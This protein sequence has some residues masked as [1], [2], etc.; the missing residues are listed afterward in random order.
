M[1]NKKNLSTSE[2]WASAGGI[3]HHERWG[4]PK[5][6][7]IVHNGMHHTREKSYTEWKLSAARVSGSVEIHYS[8][9]NW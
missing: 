5:A 8:V 4:L 3:W 9:G 6:A 7:E 1:L 2:S